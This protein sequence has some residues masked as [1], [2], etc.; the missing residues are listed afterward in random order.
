MGAEQVCT[1][2]ISKL[3]SDTVR[4]ASLPEQLIDAV[5]HVGGLLF[6]RNRRCHLPGAL[7]GQDQGRVHARRL[8]H[9]DIG[10]DAVTDHDAFIGLQSDST[11]DGL[12]H[13]PIG[14]AD[15]HFALGT[16]AGFDGRHGHITVNGRKADIPSFRVAENDIVE[17]AVSSRELTPFV[18]ARAEAGERPVPA[19]LEVIPS[20]MR[21][22]VHQLPVRA[23]IDTAVQEQLI[24]ELY[25]K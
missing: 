2:K 7:A 9:G 5:E 8:P 15:I 17:V 23:Q 6:G 12:H 3:S 19:W 1:S 13:D 24:V 14:L 18:V 4:T 22:L 20:K 16:G 21:V 10:V 11:H 25:S